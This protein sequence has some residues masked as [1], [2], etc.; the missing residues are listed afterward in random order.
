MSASPP[1]PG[2]THPESPFHQGEQAVQARLGV[3]EKVEA[4]GRKVVRDYLPEQQR[5]FYSL[6]PLLVVAML[7]RE[8]QPWCSVVAGAPGFITSPDDRS[9]RIAAPI[10]SGDPLA[11][12]LHVGGE[13]GIVGVQLSTRRR[14]RISGVISAVDL[15]GFT[16]HVKQT[17]GNCP[18]Y[19][20][21]REFSPTA[22]LGRASDKKSRFE[23][24]ALPARGQQIIA[25]A[26]TL[27][28]ATA[29]LGADPEDSLRTGVDASHRG[30]KP[31]FVR[32]ED[33]RTLTIPDFV[34]NFIFNTI[35]NLTLEPRAGLVFM[36]FPTGDML[37]L[38]GEAEIIWDGE[39]VK[40]FAGAERLIRFRVTRSILVDGSLP[41]RFS[42]PEF[43]PILAR[44][45]SW[46]DAQATLAAAHERNLYR[47]Y[48]IE[49]IVLESDLVKSF[50][51]EPADGKGLAPYEAGQFLPIRVSP[52]G[53]KKPL[54]RTYTLS[55]A[56][57][58]R[59]YRLS[60]KREGAASQ[61]LHGLLQGDVIEAVAPRGDFTFDHAGRRPVVMIAGGIGVT[62]LLA[63]LNDLL[64]NEGR[65][66]HHNR[67]FFIQGV[68]D[69]G[70][71]PFR[72]HLRAK[73]AK[74]TNFTYHARYSAPRPDDVLG[75]AH[76]SEG[77]IDKA[78]LQALLPLDDYD[79]YLCGPSG[80]MQSL[81]DTVRDMGVPD[82][83]IRFE[84]FG[85]ASVYR[86][87]DA[88]AATS[89]TLALG[90]EEAVEVV[91]SRSGK[92]ARWTPADGTLL[93]LAEA[94]G[95]EP[96]YSCRNG[97]CGTCAVKIVS[98]VVDYREPPVA[99]V[100]EGEALICCSTPRPGPHL[101]GR[102]D[103]EG[104]ALDL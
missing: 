22:E 87:R 64:V 49:R 25:V 97:V 68:R 100:R 59:G 33:A 76:D 10:L 52:P 26:D 4:Q 98:G 47:P 1:I 7:D 103:R 56:P 92:R 20:Q 9:L 82:A 39:E 90:A 51:L 29:H 53:A 94:Q 32:V 79:F 66:R 3:R 77:R 80:F 72:E 28:I 71:H 2:W 17:L 44:T 74:H 73:A 54:M 55:D 81:Y 99:E 13:I 16:V 95:L 27:F 34:G 88:K 75:E 6:L 43:S 85:P 46:A 93:E 36:D 91:F 65:T 21:V 96:A 45:G 70:A 24:D 14:N 18:Q 30:G 8:G 102:I 84:S 19:I 11:D 86:R 15:D 58:G 62:P 78:L 63:M 42:A 101:E 50:Y 60:V 23:S 57:N 89:A 12:N 104:V 5:E 61:L 48:R 83:R 69:G 38:A 37:Y 41:L 35:G 40:S 67:I 31:G